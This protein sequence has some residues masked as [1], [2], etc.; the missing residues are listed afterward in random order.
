MRLPH[1]PTLTVKEMNV[2]QMDETLLAFCVSLNHAVRTFYAQVKQALPEPA[3]SAHHNFKPG[4]LV[5]VK[6]YKRKNSL[7][8][9]CCG[10]FLILLTTHTAVK[11]KGRATWIHTTH[12]KLARGQKEPEENVAS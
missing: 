8:A 2:Q 9:R 10:P 7:Q 5:Y 12:C 3:T 4:D 6:I 11:C 1:S